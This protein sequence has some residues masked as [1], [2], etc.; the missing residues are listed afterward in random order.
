ML[1]KVR[2][3]VKYGMLAF[4][5]LSAIII[6]YFL[7]VI[8]CGDDN[9]GEE[10]TENTL[11]KCTNHIDDDNDGKI[12]CEDEE[13]SSFCQE[14]T[15]GFCQDG[16]D[17]DGDEKIDCD[18]ED[19]V[20]FC[21]AADGD[22][23]SDGDADIIDG[24]NEVDIKSDNT[25]STDVEDTDTGPCRYN[26][27]RCERDEDCVLAVNMYE[28]CFGF[29]HEVI[30]NQGNSAT[31][32]CA[33]AE[34]KDFVACDPC[35]IEWHEGMDIPQVPEECRPVCGII[36]CSEGIPGICMNYCGVPC[37]DP[38]IP[39][40]C[41]DYCMMMD[42]PRCSNPTRA[43]CRNG[44]CV[45]FYDCADDSDC[46]NGKCIDQDGDGYKE[47]VTGQDE[48]QVDSDCYTNDCNDCRCDDFDF[49]GFKECNCF[50]MDASTDV[51]GDTLPD[52]VPQHCFTDMDCAPFYFCENNTCVYYPGHCRVVTGGIDCAT[53]PEC[54]NNPC[55]CVPQDNLP[56]GHG[57]CEPLNAP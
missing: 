12:D 22:S 32:S 50:C 35:V 23:D 28:C 26:T 40:E 54:Q 48:C 18:D 16:I 9:G 8:S 43:V 10:K 19:C 29:P 49:D 6:T 37:S 24:G 25:T 36:S 55:D 3:R 31:Q 51:Q 42:C 15:P 46:T 52:L 45:E 41:K 20:Q 47:C 34:H 1:F 4:S 39:D 33:T 44:Q 2:Q 5:V 14:N 13:C 53:L 30:D 27:F 17:N 57:I 11:T 7:V 38:R 21:G 56:E